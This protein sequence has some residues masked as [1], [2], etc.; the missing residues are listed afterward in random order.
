MLRYVIKRL[1]WMIPVLLGVSI[2]VFAIQALAP[3][4]PADLALGDYASNEAK[5]EWREEHGLNKPIV[6]QYGEYM[7]CLLYTSDAADE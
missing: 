2:L 6:V 3:G 4:D 5:Y 7:Y 1:L